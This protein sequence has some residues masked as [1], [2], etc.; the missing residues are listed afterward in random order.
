METAITD[1]AAE[2]GYV[3]SQV[4]LLNATAGV[5]STE[6]VNLLSAEN[7]VTATDYSSATSQMAKDEILLQTGISALAQANSTQQLVTKLLQ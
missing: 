4:N 1:I 2:R 5:M 7:N 6:S 3:G